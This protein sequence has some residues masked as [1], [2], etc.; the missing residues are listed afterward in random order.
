MRA[1]RISAT[2]TIKVAI[3]VRLLSEGFQALGALKVPPSA[4]FVGQMPLEVLLPFVGGRAAQASKSAIICYQ[5]ICKK[6][7]R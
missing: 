7:L 5:K 3:E 2:L 1:A 4:T 6:M